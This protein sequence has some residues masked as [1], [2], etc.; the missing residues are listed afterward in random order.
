VVSRERLIN[1]WLVNTG[2]VLEERLQTDEQARPYR[3]Q[4]EDED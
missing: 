2:F 4:Y 3:D 1:V